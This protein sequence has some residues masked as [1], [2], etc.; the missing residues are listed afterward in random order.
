MNTTLTHED[1][2]TLFKA[3][4][5]VW[6]RLD[7]I[8]SKRLSQLEILYITLK[9]DGGMVDVSTDPIMRSIAI[10]DEQEIELRKKYSALAQAHAAA[11]DA[12]SGQPVGANNHLPL[13]Q[14]V[15]PQ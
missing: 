2:H 6:G 11:V 7:M 10:L 9:W 4:Q 15:T 5:D 12:L 8:K 14:T 13:R 3:S 1:S